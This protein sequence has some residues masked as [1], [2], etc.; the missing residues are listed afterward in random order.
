MGVE[1]AF[2]TELGPSGNTLTYSTWL[3]G[4]ANRTKATALHWTAPAR[5]SHGDR[6]S[7]DFPVVQPASQSALKGDYDAF[8][9]KLVAPLVTITTVPASLPIVV[10]GGTAVTAPQ[11]FNWTAGS[12]H[13]ISVNSPQQGG[14]GTRYV[15]GNWSDGGAQTHTVTVPTTPTTYTATF[16]TQFL[17]T[18][19]VV[20]AG[21]AVSPLIPIHRWLLRQ[22]GQRTVDRDSQ[23]GLRALRLDPE[24][25]TRAGP[26][27]R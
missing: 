21:T 3:G 14:G 25:E 9:L 15:F 23:P 6:G 24:P 1:N 7:P 13:T 18:T 11:S 17:L 5:H 16:K 10:D 12:T 8:V 4:S 20:P 19:S 26:R 22:R 27:R 2:V